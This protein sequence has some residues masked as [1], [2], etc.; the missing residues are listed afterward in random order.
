[1]SEAVHQLDGIN[2]EQAQSEAE[3][4][5]DADETM[6]P[7]Q[8]DA[9]VVAKREAA[10]ADK[11]WDTVAQRKSYFDGWKDELLPFKREVDENGT[12][13]PEDFGYLPT[14]PTNAAGDDF[15]HCEFSDGT[16]HEISEM[17]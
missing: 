4:A 15:A 12:R 17:T 3:D 11:D 13:V 5:V 1:M 16:K 9:E 2:V 8:D 7:E 14:I 10:K 6:R